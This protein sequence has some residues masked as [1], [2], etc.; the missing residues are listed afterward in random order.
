MDIFTLIY[1]FSPLSPSLWETARYRLK[2]CLKASLSPKTTNQPIM[3][4]V[5]GLSAYFTDWYLIYLFFTV[6][7]FSG[8]KLVFYVYIYA[9]LLY[10]RTSTLS[11]FFHSVSFC[12]SIRK[13]IHVFEISSGLLLPCLSTYFTDWC[14]VYLFGGQDNSS[15]N[16]TGRKFMSLCLLLRLSFFLR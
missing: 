13:Y 12:N 14:L 6:R 7:I 16:T 11:T 4:I 10:L 8:R 15:Y 9:C 3:S 5:S 1:P 2:Y